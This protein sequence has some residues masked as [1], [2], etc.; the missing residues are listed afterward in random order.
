[1]VEVVKV[2]VKV[3]GKVVVRVVVKVV[4]KV[5]EIALKVVD[6]VLYMLELVNGARCALWVLGV[7]LYILFCVLLCVLNATKGELRLLEVLE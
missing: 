7:M 3:V 1:M 2:V 5:V 6:V 4:V